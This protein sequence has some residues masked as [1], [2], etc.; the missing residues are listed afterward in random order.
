MLTDYHVRSGRAKCNLC[1][2]NL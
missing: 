1:E 2:M